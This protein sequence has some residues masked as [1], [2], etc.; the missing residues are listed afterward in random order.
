MVYKKTVG[1][2]LCA[3]TASSPQSSEASHFVLIAGEP[4]REPVF[5]HGALQCYF[6]LLTIL[7]Y[8]SLNWNVIHGCNAFVLFFFNPV[9]SAF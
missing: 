4:I 7:K 5:Q 8:R 1:A 2:G 3:V 9:L 6:L